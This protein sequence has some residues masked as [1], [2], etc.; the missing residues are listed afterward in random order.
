MRAL[1][2]FGGAGVVTATVVGGPVALV[3][4]N[5]ALMAATTAILLLTLN[6]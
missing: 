5:L 3:I 1:A 2:L 4:G 6:L